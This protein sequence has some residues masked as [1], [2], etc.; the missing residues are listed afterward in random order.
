ME[1]SR[2][3]DGIELKR[4]YSRLMWV[5]CGKDDERST[6]ES[7]VSTEDSKDDGDGCSV[8]KSK[9]YSHGDV[10]RKSGGNSLKSS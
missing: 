3:I 8:K 2:R 4:M 10:V 6:G 5:K 7:D 9:K 1:E